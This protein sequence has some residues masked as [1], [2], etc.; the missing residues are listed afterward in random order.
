MEYYSVLTLFPGDLIFSVSEDG[1]AWVMRPRG[2]TWDATLLS[3]EW[4]T[5]I[6]VGPTDRASLTEVSCSSDAH[7]VVAAVRCTDV[8]GTVKFGIIVWEVRSRK[9]LHFLQRHTDEII[10]VLRANQPQVL[11]AHPSQVLCGS[12]TVGTPYLTTAGTPCSPTW[13]QVLRACPPLLLRDH[14]S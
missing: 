7:F 4:R 6:G 13:T 2:T 14:P 12:P 9:F 3:A 11:L 8:R 10:K 1:T 5:S